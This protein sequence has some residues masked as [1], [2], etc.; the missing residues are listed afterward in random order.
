MLAQKPR[1]FLTRELASLVGIE[2]LGRTIAAY[3]VLH[4]V[5][6]KQRG[7]ECFLIAQPETLA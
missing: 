2:D 4:G 1:E 7:R 3:G 6:S 5:E